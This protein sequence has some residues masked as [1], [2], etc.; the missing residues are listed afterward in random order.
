MH[1][2]SIDF[3][4]SPLWVRH[5]AAQ[6][7]TADYPPEFYHVDEPAQPLPIPDPLRSLQQYRRYY[8]LDSPTTDEAQ[9]ELRRIQPLQYED[10]WFA[11][12]ISW[13]QSRLHQPEKPR[14]VQPSPRRKGIEI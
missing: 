11:T 1:E 6:G 9:R 7:L 10:P 12:R 5:Y 3:P 14:T 2:D 8:L 13:L 4:C